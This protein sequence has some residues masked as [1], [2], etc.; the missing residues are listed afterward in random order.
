MNQASNGSSRISVFPYDV[1]LGQPWLLLMQTTAA[2]EYV[3][4]P[5]VLVDSY[6]TSDPL[7][8]MDTWGELDGVFAV[9]GYNNSAESTVTIG[10]TTYLMMQNI[11]RT[12]RNNYWALAEA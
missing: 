11:F 2:T 4:F 5:T 1:S 12:A 6:S 9:A 3:L 7:N 8:A 10:S